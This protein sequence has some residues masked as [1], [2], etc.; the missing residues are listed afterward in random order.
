MK[1]RQNNFMAWEATS[2][3][4][5]DFKKIY[6]DVTGDL[7]AGLLL[8]Q[9]IYWHLPDKQGRHKLRVRKQGKYWLAKQR[10]DWW[11]EIRITPKQYDR[12]IKVLQEI[13]VVEVWN[14]MFDGKRTPHIY[15]CQDEL[16]KL[17]NKQ[18]EA[19]KQ[20]NIT[21]LPKGKNRSLPKGNTGIDEKVTPITE[22]T[23][24]IT[25]EITNLHHFKNDESFLDFY[26]L[27]YKDYMDKDHPRVTDEQESYIEEIIKLLQDNEVDYQRWQTEVINHFE[28]LPK[29]N[30]G[31]ILA[32][33]MAIK[34]RFDISEQYG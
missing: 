28:N 31:N 7:I 22:T 6:V 4:T 16:I 9:I 10:S 5:I 34:R 18:I 25:T 30:N 3:D 14:T 11:D 12:A 29:S 1:E 26:L 24:E 20:G 32:F 27:A 15:L 2:R 13:K 33:L 19:T 8:S 23:T 17:I 21:V